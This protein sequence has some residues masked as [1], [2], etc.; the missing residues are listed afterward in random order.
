MQSVCCASAPFSKSTNFQLRLVL[1]Q[2]ISEFL[3]GERPHRFGAHVAGRGEFCEQVE[4]LLLV[5][6]AERDE[7]APRDGPT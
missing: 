2:Q 6:C 3:V 1:L 4:D 5:I 7:R